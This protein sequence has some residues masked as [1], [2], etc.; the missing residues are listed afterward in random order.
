MTRA[1]LEHIIRAAGAIANSVDLVVIGSQSVPGQF[2]AAPEA[3]L[4]SNEADI[5][6]R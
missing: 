1:A 5:F 6:P 4:I 2:P 3:L